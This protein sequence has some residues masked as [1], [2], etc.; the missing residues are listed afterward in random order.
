MPTHPLLVHFPIVFA[1]LVPFAMITALAVAKKTGSFKPVWTAV[2]GLCLLLTVSAFV[3]MEFGENEEE[4]VEKVVSEQV[5]ENHEESAEAFAWA[6]LL[7]LFLSG[8]LLYKNNTPLKVAAVASGIVVLAL[9]IKTGHSGAELVYKYN[10]GSAYASLQSP[11]GAGSMHG[12][13]DM[14][15][16]DDDDD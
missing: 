14:E 15:D 12:A 11:I 7:P 8:L 10:A 6:T 9:V 16:D 4:K 3:T 1:V 13:V 5:M 2:V